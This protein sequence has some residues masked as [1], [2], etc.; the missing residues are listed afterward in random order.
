MADRLTATT[1]TGAPTGTVDTGLTPRS[2]TAPLPSLAYD[3]HGNTTVLGNQ[4]MT[5]G[6]SDRHLT[7]TVV[8]AAGTSTVSY[9][10]DTPGQIV[11]RTTTPPTGPATTI[12]YL[13]AGG[14]LFG[15][16]SG[17]GSAVERDLTLPGG[18]SARIPAGTPTT[19]AAA[20]SWSYPNLHGDVIVQADATGT[21]IGAVASYDP[22]GQPI[23]PTTGNIG[24]IASDQTVPDTAAGSADFGWVG[25]NQKLAELQG[26]IS[27]IEMGVRQYLPGLGR[28]LSC[29]PVEGGVT[30]S[31]D[32]P[33]DPI[34][35]MDLSGAL[36]A[37][38]AD[39][40]AKRGSTL[41]GLDG[42]TK[43]RPF[44]ASSRDASRGWTLFETIRA[45]QNIPLSSIGMVVADGAKCE[46]QPGG[47]RICYKDIGGTMTLGNTIVTSA[48]SLPGTVLAHEES[49]STQAAGLGNFAFSAVWLFGLALSQTD[50]K[51]SRVGGGGC[52]NIVEYY[53]VRGG[54]YELPCGW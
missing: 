12:R 34:N 6:V 41:N 26:S 48:S 13:Y 46:W 28:F 37:D 7:T 49:H 27:T 14:S 16:D 50:G 15:T 18:V 17:V 4:S 45:L 3:A 43:D 38:G 24:T 23:D 11:S 22:F 30:N 51:Y 39:A 53:A 19:P 1:V 10:R 36:S 47:T 2:T 25:S 40:W 35:R 8:D 21:R 52:S 9:V 20:S 33:A 29:D 31:Y 54:G 42:M 44:L 5:Y 32:Y